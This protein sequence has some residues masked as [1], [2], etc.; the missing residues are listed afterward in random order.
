IAH[1]VPMLALPFST[2]Q[3]DGAAAIEASG[4]GS[5]NDPNCLT[6]T[7]V[8]DAVRRLITAPSPKLPMLAQAIAAR[9]GPTV[10]RDALATLT[11]A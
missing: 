3:F 11:T 2:D 4:I 5:A 7:H 10:A 6:T 1:G 8:A 9:P